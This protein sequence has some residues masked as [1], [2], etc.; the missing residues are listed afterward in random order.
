MVAV[1]GFQIQNR[2][3]GFVEQAGIALAADVKRRACRSISVKEIL[4]I[5]RIGTPL[6]F[7][8]AAVIVEFLEKLRI[9]RRRGDNQLEV[10]AFLQHRLENA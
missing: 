2:I 8:Y 4:H 5:H 9:K 1:A 3:A 10:G 7:E 6:G